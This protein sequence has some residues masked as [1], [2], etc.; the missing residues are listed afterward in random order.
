MT[1]NIE[2]IPVCNILKEAGISNFNL[3]YI[4]IGI[5]VFCTSLNDF[6]TAISK[7]KEKSIHFFT[8]DV[9]SEKPSKFI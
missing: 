9:P 6:H 8:H 5:K 4:S 3:K 1:T 7:L 2:Y